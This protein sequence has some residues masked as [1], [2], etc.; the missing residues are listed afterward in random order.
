V[1]TKVLDHGNELVNVSIPKKQN[2][3]AL[4]PLS[5]SLM[6]QKVAIKKEFN[7]RFEGEEENDGDWEGSISEPGMEHTEE[8]PENPYG[9]EIA[10]HLAKKP[11]NGP[12]DVTNKSKNIAEGGPSLM[13]K[14]KYK[15]RPIVERINIATTTR[16]AIGKTNHGIK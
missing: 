3:L 1:P 5:K 11:N 6:V 2:P 9:D 12:N 7:S 4:Q 10:K 15:K 14:G 16:H 8:E 13:K